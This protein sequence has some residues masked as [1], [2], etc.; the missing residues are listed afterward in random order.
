[1]IMKDE[2]V[3]SKDVASDIDKA[4]IEKTNSETE[5]LQLKIAESNDKYL[6]AMAE[7]EN[8]R[9]RAAMDAQSAARVRAIAVAEK[10]LPLIDA[11]SAA[12][13]HQPGNKDFES[14]KLTASGALESAGIKK[15]ESVGQLL[16]PML[17]NAI[18]AE[19]SDE[20]SGTI[21]QEFQS[22]YIFGDVVMRPAA[23]IVAK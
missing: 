15:I 16:N 13:E 14:L 11:I 4:K 1:M 21:I 23:V 9:R 8:T 6:R 18:H 22:G 12:L 2:K 20:P 5:E 7:L 3:V 10:F 19:E 17:H